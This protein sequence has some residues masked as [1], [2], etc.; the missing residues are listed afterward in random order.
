MSVRTILFLYVCYSLTTLIGLMLKSDY[1]YRYR[2][3]CSKLLYHYI[4]IINAEIKVMLEIKML[5]GTLQK[6]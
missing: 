6:L 5:Q 4:I 1:L 3:V 2:V